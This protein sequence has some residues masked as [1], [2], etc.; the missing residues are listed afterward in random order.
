LG[1]SS[2]FF[3]LENAAT[4]IADSPLLT[5]PP[6][7]LIE[8]MEFRSLPLRQAE[9]GRPPAHPLSTSLAVLGLNNAAK[10][11]SRPP[12]NALPQASYKK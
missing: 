3:T 7:V 11:G 4:P 5:P 9:P 12:E 8:L 6:L 2:L 10:V 1:V